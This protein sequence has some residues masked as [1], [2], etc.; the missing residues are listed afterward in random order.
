M[1]TTILISA[2]IVA[3][4]GAVYFWQKPILQDKQNSAEPLVINVED[5]AKVVA[6][7][8]KQIN[9]LSPTPPTEDSWTVRE[10]EFVK[11][12]P[13]AYVVYHDTHNIF[14]ILVETGWRPY[15]DDQK[16]KFATTYQTIAAF[17][18]DSTGWRLTGGEDLAKGKETVKITNN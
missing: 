2:I 1:K 8:G 18:A 12:E 7:I 3:G 14:R 5:Y 11:G 4:I 13:Y 6:D 16:N 17:E 9:E 10:V 15:Q